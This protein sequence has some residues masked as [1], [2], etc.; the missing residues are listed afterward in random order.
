MRP[1][2]THAISPSHDKVSKERLYMI[3]KTHQSFYSIKNKNVTSLEAELSLV[4]PRR[5]TFLM[6][7]HPDLP[8]PEQKT[9]TCQWMKTDEP[10]ID[11]LIA[12]NKQ[13]W[14]RS[15]LRSE[16]SPFSNEQLIEAACLSFSVFPQCAA[17]Y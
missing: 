6:V 10:L 9:A 15:H 3:T 7:T 17:A 13:N 8:T 4:S 16:R 11:V 1:Y 12:F 2:S 5:L 14:R